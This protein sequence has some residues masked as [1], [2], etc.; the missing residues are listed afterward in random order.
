MISCVDFIPVYNEFFKFLHAKGGKPAVVHFWENLSDVFLNNL[1]DLAAKK[2]L[3]GCFE[4]WSHT[5]TEEAADFRMI[6]DEEKG[7]FEIQM[8][9][10]PSMGRLMEYEHIEPYP[11][12]CEHCDTLYRRVLE[13]LGFDYDIDLSQCRRATCKITAKRRLQPNQKS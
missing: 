5:L 7:V 2:G 3:A 10:C 12:Y 11:Y 1:R 9:H 13:P 4:Y 8:R 6:L